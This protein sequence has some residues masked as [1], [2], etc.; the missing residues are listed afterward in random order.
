MKDV[1]EEL[2]DGAH[3]AFMQEYLKVWP[4][5]ALAQ[6]RVGQTLN[7]EFDGALRRCEVD[8]MDC[9]LIQ[10]S[11]KVSCFL[12]REYIVNSFDVSDLYLYREAINLRMSLHFYYL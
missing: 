8:E 10:I 7:V 3:K 6:Y 5:P 2:T 11:F 12:D 1:T 9:S 4:N